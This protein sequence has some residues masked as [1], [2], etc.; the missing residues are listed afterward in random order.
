MFHNAQH[1]A[2]WTMPAKRACTPFAM[3]AG[4]IDFAGDARPVSKLTNEFMAGRSGESIVAALQLQIGGTDA[5]HK[6]P[7][8][9]KSLPDARRRLLPYFDSS[10]FQMN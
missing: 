4:E 10:V 9:R 3:A 8:A 5:R 2:I 6:H 7:N 1:G